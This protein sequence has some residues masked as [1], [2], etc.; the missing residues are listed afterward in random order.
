VV[1]YEPRG[2]GHLRSLVDKVFPVTRAR[3]G[4]EQLAVKGAT[5]L[6]GVGAHRYRPKLRLMRISAPIPTWWHHC[7]DRSPGRGAR[8]I[9]YRGEDASRKIQPCGG[10]PVGGAFC[11]AGVC[12]DDRGNGGIICG[13]GDNTT[14]TQIII[15]GSRKDRPRSYS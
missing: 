11:L 9:G 14:P 4:G 7:I 6:A 1:A 10:I 5:R 8:A 2:L 15:S 3:L 12:G 13:G